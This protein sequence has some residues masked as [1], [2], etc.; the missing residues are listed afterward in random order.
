LGETHCVFDI[1][2]W[3]ECAVV[4]VGEERDTNAVVRAI[5]ARDRQVGARELESMPL[6]RRPVGGTR[7]ARAPW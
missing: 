6:V 3:H 1:R 2:G 7:D 5:E 4:D